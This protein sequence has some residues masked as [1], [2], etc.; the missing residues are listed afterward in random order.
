L[1]LVSTAIPLGPAKLF[2]LT[3]PLFEVLEEKLP[4]CPKTRS[5]VVSPLPGVAVTVRGVLYSSTRTLPESAT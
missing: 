3:P 1:P 2:L 5:A 4:P